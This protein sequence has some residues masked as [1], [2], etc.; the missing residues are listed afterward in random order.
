MFPRLYE[1]CRAQ[2]IVASE[3]VKR[4]LGV[5]VQGLF[6]PHCLTPQPASWSPDPV[7][8]GLRMAL[9]QA[10]PW[11]VCFQGNSTHSCVSVELMKSVSF[12]PGPEFILYTAFL[13]TN[14]VHN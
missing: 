5:T 6:G 10:E 2:S 9:C 4:N 1:G 13:D 14:H 12:M 3:T 7:L 8:S 11:L